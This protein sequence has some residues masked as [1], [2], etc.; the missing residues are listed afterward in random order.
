M[1]ERATLNPLSPRTAT[2]LSLPEPAWGGS[3]TSRLG[4]VISLFALLVG[5]SCARSVA[6]SG[7]VTFKLRQWQTDDGLPQNSVR[8]I[9]QAPDGYLW[10]GTD[11]GVVRFD[12]ITFVPLESE[13]FPQLRQLRI[14]ALVAD[15][16]GGLWIGTEADGLFVLKS[17]GLSRCTSSNGL[18]VGP[19]RSLLVTRN[20]ELWIGT[21]SGLASP[22][23]CTDASGKWV[24]V[25]VPPVRA[26]LEDRDG[27]L[28]IGTTRG[29]L[30]FD[31]NLRT[32]L[33]NRSP[34]AVS[35]STRALLRGEDERLWVA[36]SDGLFASRTNQSP[37][38]PR[39]AGL[40]SAIVTSLCSGGAGELWVGSFGGL[41]LL[42]EGKVT[43]W[44]ELGKTFDDPVNTLFRDREG[45]LWVGAKSGLYRL[46]PSQF[47][48]LTSDQG[49]P[50]NN[51]VS[52]CEDAS[53]A[54]WAAIWG[55]GL[56][57][58]QGGNFLT[59]RATN[60]LTHESVLALHPG[61]DGF[62]WV[63]FDFGGGLNRITRGLTNNY[64]R[65]GNSVPAA[66]RVIHQDRENA[67][68]VGTSR[69]L[70]RFEGESVTA[71]TAT[72]G[73]AGNTVMALC[74]TRTG[75]L[76]IGTDGGLNRWAEG[77]FDSFKR[78]AGLSHETILALHEDSEGVLWIG[79]KAG[80]LNRLQG[81]VFTSYST[82]QGLFSD[83][84]F[85]IVEDDFGYLWMSCRRG[86]FR[87]AKADFAALDR[88]DLKQLNCVS[89]GRE[90]GLATAQFNGVAKPAGWKARDGQLW[91]PTIRG[92]VAVEARILPNQQPPLVA[93]EQ[94]LANRLVLRP[95]LSISNPPPVLQV[96]PG[97][98]ELELHY[99]ALSLQAPE[100]NRFRHRLEGVDSDWVDAGR[101]RVANYYALRPGDY[102][103]RVQ[104]C[105][106]DGIWSSGE[107]SLEIRVAPHFWETWV[108]KALIAAGAVGLLVAFY[109]A[110]LGR[111]REIERLR[112]RIASDLHDDVGS[113]L[114][115]VAMVT[116]AVEREI[117]SD[118]AIKPMI[119]SIARTVRE[120]TRAM[121]EIVWTINPRNDAL[122]NLASYTYQY[123]EEYFRGTRVRCRLD[124]PVELPNHTI[125]TE[126]RHNL[127]MAFKECLNNVLKHARASEVR[128]TLSLTADQL[129]FVIADNGV[130]LPDD[131]KSPA[132]EGL[133][134]MRER[135]AQIG[136]RMEIRSDP[137][138]G[139]VVRLQAPVRRA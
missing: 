45:N 97:A 131:P 30:E 110:R 17:G 125:S 130:G 83:E 129:T 43:N 52:V 61:R 127:F 67:L 31:P 38:W 107:A 68:W 121:D 103:F 122:D 53:G 33:T 98:R 27:R 57:R 100:R 74:E 80:G 94:V 47:H 95:A 72:N 28:Q 120:I 92:V 62:L 102:R 88:G 90:D 56:T 19:V 12:G 71:F 113:R 91:F 60:G 108:F 10:V 40:P 73:L 13:S 85:E 124:F 87:V 16:A 58:I 117:A 78:S 93:I 50:G 6:G 132:G 115:K 2:R 63:G 89:Y 54:L 37:Q 24:A 133:A 34:A 1:D 29:L 109:R 112:I 77:R 104:A 48:H 84:V 39:V 66:V 135:L 51:V 26:L 138:E 119:Q 3:R 23:K 105:N 49:L 44:Q 11:E 36:T 118:D 96:P 70:F 41:T 9:C 21:D 7:P 123:A 25:S 8:A 76:W 128:V 5:F 42:F 136:G 99:S 86:L 111:L 32:V 35:G 4:W 81:G 22:G 134:N 137:G 20:Q 101:R 75:A 106:N 46:T 18:P 55:T 65:S 64:P 69:G 14:T 79:T 126:E 82:A 15:R 59:L 139:T 114:T 116:E